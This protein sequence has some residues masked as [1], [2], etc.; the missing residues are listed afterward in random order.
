M[1][2][3]TPL[4][5]DQVLG[6]ADAHFRRTGRWPT[7]A[8]GAIPGAPGESWSRIH[9]ALR[10]GLRGLPG[11]DSLS[12]FLARR[13]GKPVRQRKAPLTEVLILSWADAHF[14][15]LGRWPNAAS[16]AVLEAPGENWRAVN[17]ALWTGDRGL[18]GGSSVAR[19]LRK[20]GRGKYAVIRR[21]AGT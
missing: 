4:I 12:Q 10:R 2:R 14:H 19:L 18:R 3:R 15:R 20:T 16:G 17:L 1:N 21:A 11:G 5:V 6:W 8:C 9:G 13:R 7:A